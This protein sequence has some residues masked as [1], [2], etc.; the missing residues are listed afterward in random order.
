MPAAVAIVPLI[1]TLI[2]GQAV[3]REAYQVG[4]NPRVRAELGEDGWRLDPL[5]W[6][7]SS[8]LA[9]P[10]LANGYCRFDPG[11]HDLAVGSMLDWEPLGAQDGG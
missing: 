11:E 5:R 2:L 1:G 10:A 4:V 6:R 7:G 9:G 8:D 3:L